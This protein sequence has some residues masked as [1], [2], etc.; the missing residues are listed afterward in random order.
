MP[1]TRR[2]VSHGALAAVLVALCAPHLASAQCEITGPTVLCEGGSVTLCAPPDGEY[3]WWGPGITSSSRCITVTQP[4]EYTVMYYDAV[5]G[6]GFEPCSQVVTAGAGPRPVASITGP[7]S[8]CAGDVVDLCGPAG[9]F[10]YQWSGPNGFSSIAQCVAVRDGGAYQL[11][12]SPA[13]GAC[14]SLPASHSIE[15]SNCEPPPSSSSCPRPPSWWLR[16][17]SGRKASV[18]MGALSQVASCVDENS[19]ALDFKRESLCKTL[20]HRHDLRSRARR[21]VAAIWASACAGDL[22]LDFGRGPGVSLSLSTPLDLPGAKTTVGEWLAKADAD[23]VALDQ[24]RRRDRSVKHAYREIIRVGWQIDHGRGMGPVC[25]EDS[26]ERIAED[27]DATSELADDGVHLELE[28]ASSPTAANI[29][30][31]VQ[32]DAPEDV[33]VAVYDVA[34]RLVANLA[35][36]SHAP[37]EYSIRWNGAFAGGGSARSGVYFVRGRIRDQVTESKLVLLR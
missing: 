11:V 21:H 24:R 16:Q 35:S 5:N 25:V 28:V 20:R 13:S 19:A 9:D 18:P 7:A 10:T 23:L 6:L 17:C 34:G 8:A 36:G 30:F 32:A 33:S 12:V 15:F 27:V 37:G 31:S 3:E 2:A 29:D 14:A 22:G 4:G 26:P 1:F